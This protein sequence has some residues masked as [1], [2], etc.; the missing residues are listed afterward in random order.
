MG[1]RSAWWAAVVLASGCT[2]PAVAE[3]AEGSATGSSG[4]SSGSSSSSSDGGDGPTPTD[5]TGPD[6]DDLPPPDPLPPDLG[7]GEV[8]EVVPHRFTEVTEAAGLSELD[9]GQLLIP[10]FCTLDNLLGPPEVTGDYCLPERF[11]GAAAV[12]DFD[13]DGWPDVYLSRMDG[14]DWLLRNQG[15]GTFVDVADSAGLTQAHLTGGAAWIDIEGDG[16]LDLMLTVVGD[17]RNYLY[18]NDG[19]GHFSEEAQARGFALDYGMVHVGTSIGVGDYDLDGYLDVFVGDWHSSMALGPGPDYNRLLH[20]LGAADPGVFED[21]TEA[22]GIDMQAVS[23]EVDAPPGAWGFAPAFVDLDGDHWP[24]LALASDYRASRLWHNDG[25]GGFVDVTVMAGVGTDD[26]GMGS[27]FGDYDGDGDLDWFVTAI[28]SEDLAAP[29]NRMYRNDGGLSFTDTTDALAVRNGG[30]GWGTA[31]F[32]ADL[33]RDLDLVMTAGFPG[34][35]FGLDPVRLW[36]NTGAGPWP[37]LAVERGLEFSRQGRG[38]LTFDYDRDGDLDVL[39]HSNTEHPGLFR[40][41]VMTGSWLEVRAQGDSSGNSRG[42]GAEVRVWVDPGDAPLVRHIGVSS[43]YL[44]H[45]EAAAYFGL[46]EG[47][48]PLH[49]VEV[50]WPATGETTVLDEVPRNQLQLVSP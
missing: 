50:L 23:T 24:E 15:D 33:D 26:N 12:G 6:R 27:T 36:V 44:G 29:G 39:V 16:D 19:T 25:A 42:I 17:A 30:W 38:L 11:L 40:N 45:A 43:H 49:R 32:D 10:P 3:E 46:G 47:T 22:V 1:E 20:N 2:D 18:V 21:V 8:P 41:D 5:E 34:S 13:G 35:V 37:E 28:Y 14:P 48:E 9:P 4:A 31:M 7:D